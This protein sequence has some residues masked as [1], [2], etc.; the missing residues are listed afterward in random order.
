MS[1]P[2]FLVAYFSGELHESLVFILPI[3]LLSLV[4]GVWLLV[5]TPT[6]YTRGV[7]VPFLLVGLAMSAIGGGVGFRTP[8][9]LRGIEAQLATAPTA[10]I[11]AEVSRMAGVNARWRGYLVVWAAFGVAGMALR[12]GLAHPGARGLGSALVFFAGVGL[13]VDGFAERRAKEY[14]RDLDVLAAAP[15]SGGMRPAPPTD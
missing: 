7:A 11:S 3:G 8:S 4:F 14:A 5:D 9:Q 13:L 12:F 1:L 2:S 15:T 10:T 6:S